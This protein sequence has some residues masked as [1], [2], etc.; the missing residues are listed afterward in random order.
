MKRSKAEVEN[1]RRN[2]Q[3]IEKKKTKKGYK[4]RKN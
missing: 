2:N 3:I 1:K 4:R